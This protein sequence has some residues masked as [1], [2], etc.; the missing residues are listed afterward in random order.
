MR[1]WRELRALARVEI[2]QLRRHRARAL[3]VLLLVAVPVAAIVGGGALVVMTD[4]TPEELRAQAMG[5]ADLSVLVP[6]D[7]DER[8]RARALLPANA[9]VERLFVGSEEVRT[10]G[11]RLH[12]KLF[13]LEPEALAP[14][15]LA[16][17]M[18]RVTDGRA[19]ANAGEVALSPELL[20]GSGRGIGGR[21]TLSF[22]AVRTITGVVVDPEQL[23]LP[24]VLRT[25]AHVERGGV[26]R[27]LVDLETDDAREVAAVLDTAGFAARTRAASGT[28][29]R[30]LAAAVFA[31]G[32][33]GVLEAAL[34]VAAAFAVGVRRRQ[35]EIGLLAA[36]G[37]T[38]AGIQ[39]SLLVSAALLAAAGGVVGVL[40]GSGGALVLHPFLDGWNDRLNGRFELSLL[41]MVGGVL[42]GIAAAVFAAW[43]PARG[44]AR[45]PIRVALGGRRP[46]TTPSFVWLLL[47]VSMIGVGLALLLFAPRGHVATAA[48]GVVGGSV[49][50][51]LGFGATSPWLLHWLSHRARRLPLAWRLAVRDAGRFRTRNGPVVTA[52][53][54]GMSMT[55]TVAVLVAS[56]ESALAAFPS[57][58]RDDQLLVEGPGAQDVAERVGEALGAVGVSRLAAVTFHGE[59]IRAGAAGGTRGRDWVATGGEELL[60]VL[61]AEAG[62]E[63]FR[64]GRLLVLD[65]SG[66]PGALSFTTWVGGRAVEMPA[67]TRVSLDQTV[68]APRYLVNETR[69]ATLGLEAGLPIGKSLPP[70]LVRMGAP[71]DRTVL[72]RAQAI[73]S[74]RVGTVVDA[75]VL[76]FRPVGA[77]YRVV[78]VICIATGLVV[79]MIATALSAAES[80]Q[81]ER[82]LH[83]VGASP[84]VMRGHRA[85]RAGYLALLGCVLAV[86][87][88]M[89]P[90]VALFEAANLPLEFVMP[91]REVLLTIIGL[92]TVA[93][94]GAWL[95]G[96]RTSTRVTVS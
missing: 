42:L 19:P 69:L 71:I 6:G 43:P 96:A 89:I 58:L 60:R 1:R 8:E 51:V 76:R 35:R 94:T 18:L 74:G 68:D 49:L 10:P 30:V 33:I 25:P 93:Y 5:R 92:P 47:G 37:A 31:L 88:G 91:W 32:S 9:R 52:I 14:G 70:Y 13:A 3:L 22:G 34:V 36:S 12:A 53:V 67:L 15:G 84:R 59:P 95:F 85:A 61:G 44:A 26:H 65:A 28:G 75:A 21:V 45:L 20:D 72:A 56:L 38:I 62:A 16:E 82:V 11:L 66:D 24:V 86:P 90:A 17:G 7:F 77:F 54:A 46:I 4:A 48:I 73:A 57:A 87:A 64:A 80:L 29:D 27:L 50:G 41:H 79:V 78:L 55:V 23:D 63:A 2:R 83:T 39:A 40:L 81:D